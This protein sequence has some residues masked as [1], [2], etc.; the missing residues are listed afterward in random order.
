VKSGGKTGFW[1]RRRLFSTTLVLP[2]DEKRV[3]NGRTQASDIAP[4]PWAAAVDGP[5]GAV[6][7]VA[8]AVVLPPRFPLRQVLWLVEELDLIDFAIDLV[9]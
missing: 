7:E 9:K 2:A 8:W 6:G 4:I 3:V 1:K 5:A